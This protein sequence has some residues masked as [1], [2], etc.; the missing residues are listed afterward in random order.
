[1]VVSRKGGG[2]DER[3]SALRKSGWIGAGGEGVLIARSVRVDRC[4]Y[5]ED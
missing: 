1:M 2:G 3:V 5:R 4:R